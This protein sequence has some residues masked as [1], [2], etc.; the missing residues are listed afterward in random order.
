MADEVT[1]ELATRGNAAAI[2]QFL[3]ARATESDAVLVPHLDEVTVEQEARNIDL[4]N[5]FDDCIMLLASLGDEIVGLV[6]VM[7]LPDQPTTGE[8]GVVVAKKYW[9]NGIGRMLVDEAAY[10]FENYSSLTH[11]VLEVFADNEA[12]IK[13]YHQQGFVDEQ[14]RIE[15]GRKTIK[16]RYK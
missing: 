14:A 3:K 11:L 7:V 10:W 4:I 16:M 8:L 9:R 13:L 15:N 12:A 2:L 1:V 6:T 5:Q